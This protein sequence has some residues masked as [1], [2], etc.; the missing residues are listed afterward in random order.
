MKTTKKCRE[1]ERVT[2]VEDERKKQRNKRRTTKKRG[3]ER[4]TKEEGKNK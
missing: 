3:K 4:E 1:K 2:A